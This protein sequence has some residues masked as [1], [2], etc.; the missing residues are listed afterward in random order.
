VTASAIF[1]SVYKVAAPIIYAPYLATAVFLVGLVLAF[2]H[3][4][5]A[6]AHTEF[7]GLTE[8]EQGPVRL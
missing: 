5:R 6:P 3:P 8:S 7:A 4:G 2:V 1:G